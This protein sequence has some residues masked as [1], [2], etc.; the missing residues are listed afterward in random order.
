MC[1]TAAQTEMRR[2]SAVALLWGLYD[3]QLFQ[4]VVVRGLRGDVRGDVF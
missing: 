3:A 4:F 2:G 1:K